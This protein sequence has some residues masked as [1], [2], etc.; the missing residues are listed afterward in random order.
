MT[1]A[2]N[3]PASSEASLS[4]LQKPRRRWYQYRLRTLLLLML[5]V[6]VPLAWVRS[7]VTAHTIE[8]QVVND[9]SAIRG[10]API[11][12]G[13]IQHSIFPPSEPSPFAAH[14]DWLGPSWLQAP[15]DKLNIPVCY[16]VTE[17]S[18]EHEAFTDD[19]VDKI[20]ELRHLRTLTLYKTAISHDGVIRIAVALPDV[21]I[22]YTDRLPT[23]MP[24]QIPEMMQREATEWLDA[25]QL[26]E[27]RWQE[28]E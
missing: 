20:I 5:I 21:E 28:F 17:L 9:L 1:L 27:N 6:S 4:D 13:I 12:L 14:S 18:L 11:K 23:D 10:N 22:Q 3:Q 26:P 19:C 7:G 15:F 24:N 16:R 25:D 8:R 2:A